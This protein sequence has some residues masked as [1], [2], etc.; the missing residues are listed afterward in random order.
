MYLRKFLLLYFILISFY[1]SLSAQVDYKNQWPQFRGPYATGIIDN[2]ELPDNWNIFTGENIKW[3]I[4]IPGLG[5]S[6]PVIWDNKL[7]VTT[8]ISG[9]GSDSLKVGL[10]GDIDDLN[11]LSV[12]EFKVF[13][14]EKNTGKILWE[15]LAYKGVPKTKR[16]PK[17]SFASSTPAT[18]G[19]YVVAFFGS[20]GLYCYNF[21]GELIWEK[22]FGRMNAGPY[23]SPNVE[24]GFASSP[25]IHENRVII[26]C[27]FLGD[28]F[29]TSLDLETGKEIWHT[30]RDEI[31]TWS[32]PN[33]YNRGSNRQIIVNGWK[34]I[35]GY[36]F[37]SGKEIWKLS[38]GGGAPVPVPGF[39]H[40]LVYSQCSWSFFSNICNKT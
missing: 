8:A 30:A 3:K 28:C 38:G 4:E 17:S 13:C 34:H 29:I 2:T 19:K 12:H 21:D 35:G 24:W 26:Q 40:G 11:D 16:H 33:F 22:D 27:D 6:C 39:S 1:I 5:H 37:D 31:S 9:M 20:E 18:N 15:K 23:T 7:F 36:D 25:I 10:Y 32:T 14:I